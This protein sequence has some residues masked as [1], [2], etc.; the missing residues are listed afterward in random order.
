M[1]SINYLGAHCGLGLETFMLRYSFRKGIF[2]FYQLIKF[3]FYKKTIHIGIIHIAG[4][5]IIMLPE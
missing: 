2:Y 5:C 4:G 3:S 1:K